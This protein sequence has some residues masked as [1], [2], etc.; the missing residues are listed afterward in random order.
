MR[1]ES[2][3]SDLLLRRQI[4]MVKREG[5]W[6]ITRECFRRDGDPNF[7]VPRGTGDGLKEELIGP[8]F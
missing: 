3:A 7:E 2:A 4:P 8:L 5:R 6:I 1:A